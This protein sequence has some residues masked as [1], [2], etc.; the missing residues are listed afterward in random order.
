V[1]QYPLTDFII[2]EDEP[3]EDEPEELRE[4][5]EDVIDDV[6][7]LGEKNICVTKIR[8]SDPR[9]EIYNI[10]Y[11]IDDFYFPYK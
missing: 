11:Y 7:K 4:E 10:I 2:E 5:N 1:L 6:N 8:F 9:N 3:D